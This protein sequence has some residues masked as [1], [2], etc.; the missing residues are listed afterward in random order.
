MGRTRGKRLKSGDVC[1][2]ARRSRP[3]EAISN[4]TWYRTLLDRLEGTCESGSIDSQSPTE[5][6]PA[7]KCRRGGIMGSIW[8]REMEPASS[9]C[10]NC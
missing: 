10:F 8:H 7:Q 5:E 6:C 4:N 9:F 3:E 2:V 1:F